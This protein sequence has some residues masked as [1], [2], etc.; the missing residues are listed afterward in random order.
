MCLRDLRDLPLG[1]ATSLTFRP[2]WNPSIAPRHHR[3][4]SPLQKDFPT[5]LA[6]RE[7]RVYITHCWL[8]F[9]GCH[10]ELCL[11]VWG[12]LFTFY[13]GPLECP[14]MSTPACFPATPNPYNV[15]VATLNP[16]P[17]VRFQ[18][19][20]ERLRG[21]RC[22]ATDGA[23]PQPRQ[24]PDDRAHHHAA[25]D[26]HHRR[27]PRLRARPARAGDPHGHVVVRRRP[28]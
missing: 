14:T 16:L 26:P 8:F 5:L 1:K 10:E 23:V 3:L 13:H 17:V 11:L 25:F 19:L 2:T 22:H 9:L 15:F 4:F 18:I 20:P 21:E 28:S 6:H 24:R 12:Y 27:V 7:V